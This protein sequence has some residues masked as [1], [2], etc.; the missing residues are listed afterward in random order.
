MRKELMLI[1]CSEPRKRPTESKS[2]VSYGQEANVHWCDS[3][4]VTFICKLMKTAT[5]D[6]V[7][8]AHTHRSTL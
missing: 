6:N 3:H 7:K 1:R 5:A 8:N 4:V 2:T